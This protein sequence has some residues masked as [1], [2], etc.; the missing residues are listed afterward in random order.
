MDLAVN[1]LGAALDYSGYAS[2]VRAFICSLY[3]AGVNVTV[4]KVSH[5]RERTDH[6]WQGR[7]C[8]A[9]EQRE[10]PYRVNILHVTPDLYPNFIQHDKYNIGRLAWET[11]KLPKGWVEP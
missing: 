10:I 5:V 3:T 9:L 1:Y 2:A 7:L 6:G 8:E 11:D 4:E